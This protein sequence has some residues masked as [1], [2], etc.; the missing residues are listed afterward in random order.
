[1]VREAAGLP[2]GGM[3]LG[4]RD[5]YFGGVMVMVCPAWLYLAN[6]TQTNLK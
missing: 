3:S 6:A 5:T 2:K 4:T 1:M